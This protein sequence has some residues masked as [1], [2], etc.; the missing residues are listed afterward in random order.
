[1]TNARRILCKS[2]WLDGRDVKAKLAMEVIRT[3]VRDADVAM[4]SGHQSGNAEQGANQEYHR[5]NEVLWV[6]HRSPSIISGDVTQIRASR[7]SRM[8]SN[9]TLDAWLTKRIITSHA[10]I[11][12]EYS[13]MVNVMAKQLIPPER[14]IEL[15]N[16][17]IEAHV[18]FQPGMRISLGASLPN[19]S[20]EIEYHG[21]GTK[22]VAVDVRLKLMA[23]YEVRPFPLF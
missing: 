9:R 8:V 6:L 14:F 7:M 11:Y 13:W 18:R 22:R 19:G 21:T 16:S 10:T 17:E 12:C 1:M 5:E 4:L 2:S 20:Y 3:G 23:A 15:A